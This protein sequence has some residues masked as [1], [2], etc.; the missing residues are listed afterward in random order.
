MKK[1]FTLIE[2]LAV[3]VILAIILLIAIP[4]VINII[5]EEKYAA[6]IRS[7]E[8]Y[9]SGVEQ[10]IM[11]QKVLNNYTFNPNSCFINNNGNLLCDGNLKEL[12]IELKGE[13]PIDGKL[14]FKNGKLSYK[15]LIYKNNIIEEGE[16]TLVDGPTFSKTIKDLANNTTTSVYNSYD[17]SINYIGFYSRELPEG[18][19]L[20]NLNKLSNVSVSLDDKVRAYYDNGNIYVYGDSHIIANEN[21]YSMFRGL[22]SLTNLNLKSLDTFKTTSMQGTFK[23][24]SKLKSLDISNFD[25][26]NVTTM[27]N[28]FQDM[29]SLES[30]NLKNFNTSNVKNMAG[31]FS[32]LNSLVQLNI[33]S[34]DT[35]NVKNMNTM[36]GG[37]LLLKEL[38]LS[39]FDTSKVIDMGYMFISMNSLENLKINSFNTAKVTNMN[40]M[41]ARCYK[42]TEIDV[43]SFD[44]SNVTNM[45]SMFGNLS[46]VKKIYIS[47]KWTTANVVD[48]SNMFVNSALLEGG[49]GTKFD[50][51]HIDKTYA[52][53]D[54]GVESPG[55]LTL[56]EIN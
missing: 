6:F 31:M 32:N 36:F 22:K 19:T 2:L 25:T 17:N 39:N 4:I 33:S 16:S 3:I 9:L 45:N 28:M 14:V 48:S 7:S 53:I 38:D 56:K 54:N 12:I 15:L 34:F 35:S 42:L 49:K 52:R 1:G 23:E 18:Y 46:I 43:S 24:S 27:Y 5:K 26:S 40:H 44:T 20:E 51:V 37:S 50:F 8:F 11:K 29:T 21:M 13:K 55:Y 10:A 30:L 47:N 41:F